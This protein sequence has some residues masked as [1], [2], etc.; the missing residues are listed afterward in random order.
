MSAASAI[1][2]SPCALFYPAPPQKTV[3]GEKGRP[4]NAEPSA[5]LSISAEESKI[6]ELRQGIK[7]LGLKGRDLVDILLRHVTLQLAEKGESL[8]DNVVALPI[9]SRGGEEAAPPSPP[10]FSVVAPPPPGEVPSPQKES[11]NGAPPKPLEALETPAISASEGEQPKLPE[12]G[13]EEDW[14]AEMMAR[15]T[16]VLPTNA[17]PEEFAMLS[18]RYPHLR[19]LTC[20]AKGCERHAALT[21]NGTRY[22]LECGSA[23]QRIEQRIIEVAAGPRPDPTA[24]AKEPPDCPVCQ[25]LRFQLV[26]NDGKLAALTCST[27]DLPCEVCQGKG[28]IFDENRAYPAWV[29]CRCK[30]KIRTKSEKAITQAELPASY[31]NLLFGEL[32]AP[33]LPLSPSQ[34][35][36]HR[37]AAGWA[38]SYNPKQRTRQGFFFYGAPGTGKTLSLCR[39]LAQLAAAGI[40]TR[41]V[42]FP[43]YLDARKQEF[44]GKDVNANCI[45]ELAAFDVLLVDEILFR[46]RKGRKRSFSDWE[47]HQLDLLVHERYNEGK[48][49]L[50]ATNHNPA[51]IEDEVAESTW[52]RIR[53]TSTFLEVDGPDLRQKKG[54]GGA[55]RGSHGHTAQVAPRGAAPQTVSHPWRRTQKVKP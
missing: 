17:T 34:K 32:P 23:L 49:T 47:R 7:V 2:L 52:S 12:E 22:C 40:R 8:P 27:C 38:Q 26:D 25:N 45:Q 36:A 3:R 28:E 10:A 53:A 5:R 24:G 20:E 46:D 33:P 44:A 29:W 11:Q 18:S 37:L 21:H 4:K 35:E 13:P 16:A 55:A 30:K 41:Y 51:D 1:A 42:H 19:A 15:H 6:A 14:L 39:V 50:Y 43:L 9:P 48:P 31:L 54:R